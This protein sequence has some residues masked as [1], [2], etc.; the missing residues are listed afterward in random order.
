MTTE[1]D[2]LKAFQ[3]AYLE[4]LEGSKKMPSLDELS[5]PER[6]AARR[7]IKAL[8]MTRGINPYASRPSTS[9]LFARLEARTTAVSD[10]A[11]RATLETALRNSVD[12]NVVVDHDVASTAAGMCSRFAIR[13]QGLRIRVVVEPS[14]GDLAAA[15]GSRLTDVAA[16]FGAFTDTNAILIA[17]RDPTPIGTIVD[18]YDIGP[19]IETPSGQQGAPRLPREIGEA[20]VVCS[21]FVK[22]IMP[23]FESFRYVPTL[24][25]ASIGDL[26]DVRR[27]AADAVHEIAQSGARAKISAKRV[28]WSKVGDVECDVISGLLRDTLAGES[29]SETEYLRRI[30]EGAEA[31]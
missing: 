17:T 4:Y 18:R 8:A 1:S 13:M 5:E 2:A 22:L 25:P 26:L 28:T 31:A 29:M 6:R 24:V 16:V 7:W 3:E 12:E 27:V 11:L 21:H 10:D 23:A 30:E 15:F 19:A 14:G 9:E 20:A